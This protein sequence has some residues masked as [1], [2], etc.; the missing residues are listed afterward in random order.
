[1]GAVI[2]FPVDRVT[3]FYDLPVMQALIALAA[4]RMG[5][6]VEA[7]MA[8]LRRLAENDRGA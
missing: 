3:P 5:V 4:E 1:M 2:Q 6:S 7:F 8:H